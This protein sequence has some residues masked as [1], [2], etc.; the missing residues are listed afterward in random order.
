MRTTDV[1]IREMNTNETKSFTF[2]F[3]SGFHLIQQID[4]AIDTTWSKEG[5]IN[6]EIIVTDEEQ[7][8]D[9]EYEMLQNEGII[10]EY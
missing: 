5:D 6:V 1:K 4:E 10:F 3:E 9:E 7:F 8:F 2:E